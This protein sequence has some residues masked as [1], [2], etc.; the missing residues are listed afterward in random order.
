[1]QKLHKFRVWL[2]VV[3]FGFKWMFQVNIG[4]CVWYKG[5]KYTV[6]NGVRYDK[7]RLVGLDNGDDGWVLR[8]EC[9]LVKTPTNIIRSFKYGYGFYMGYWFDIW[10]QRGVK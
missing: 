1:M 6:I 9:S 2:R 3:W 7:W 8:S 4:N 10:C 5:N